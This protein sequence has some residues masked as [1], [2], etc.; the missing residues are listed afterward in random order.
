MIL[1]YNII[2]YA[3]SGEIHCCNCTDNKI[4]YD[5]PIFAD[6]ETEFSLYCGKCLNKIKETNL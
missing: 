5:N 3:I 6:T 2:G 4:K 1:S